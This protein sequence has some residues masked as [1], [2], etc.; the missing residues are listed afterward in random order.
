MPAGPVLVCKTCYS[1][2][3]LPTPLTAALS[4]ATSCI[5][6]GLG[7]QGCRGSDAAWRAGHLDSSSSGMGAAGVLVGGGRQAA[8][9]S[10]ARQVERSTWQG[11]SGALQKLV[12]Y[13][14]GYCC[15]AE[16]DVGT[17]GWLGQM[18]IAHAH[19]LV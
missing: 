15:C 10:A 12:S 9:R 6:S 16:R 1:P 17:V 5:T 7:E 13:C 8:V 4:A 19:T 3:P 14:N 2:P 11:L 18:L